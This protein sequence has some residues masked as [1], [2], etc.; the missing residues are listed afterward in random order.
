M[1]SNDIDLMV[2]NTLGIKV[3]EDWCVEN[4]GLKTGRTTFPRALIS[5]PQFAQP[6]GSGNKI[7][8]SKTFANRYEL[9]AYLKTVLGGDF[10]R[11]EKEFGLWTWLVVLYRDQLMPSSAAISRP[12][13]Y[14]PAEV[15]SD[16]RSSRLDQL[17]YRHC[18]RSCHYIVCRHDSAAKVLVSRNLQS[19][20]D[21]MEGVMSRQRL[22][23]NDVI[24][25]SIAHAYWDRGQRKQKSGMNAQDKPAT[26]RRFI[27]V[28]PNTVPLTYDIDYL[29]PKKVF[30]IAGREFTDSRF[31]KTNRNRPR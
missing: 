30:K 19:F 29:T 14:I 4:Y 6:Y 15:L 1:A 20:G 12:E 25:S 2:L 27:K 28:V 31:L 24:L 17:N 21:A 22:L 26:L 3:F 7:D 13:H 9:G 10:R 11:L 8:A 5:D 16:L 23:R 18:A